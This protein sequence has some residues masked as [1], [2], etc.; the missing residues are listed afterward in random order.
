MDAL[1]MLFS[2]FYRATSRYKR[3]DLYDSQGA[4]RL[5][6]AQDELRWHD[7]VRDI[8]ATVASILNDFDKERG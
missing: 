6:V 7:S 5:V 1:L 8:N 4:K 2:E 3:G